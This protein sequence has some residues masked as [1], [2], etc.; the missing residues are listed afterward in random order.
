MTK[1][2]KIIMAELIAALK[3]AVEKYGKPGGPWN[4]PIDPGGWI[5]RAKRA[6]MKADGKL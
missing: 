5:E 6:I 2:E 1:K 3:Y 4:V